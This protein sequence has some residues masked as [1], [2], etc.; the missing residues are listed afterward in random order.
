MHRDTAYENFPPRL[1][2]TKP[3]ESRSV[4]QKSRKLCVTIFHPSD[5]LSDVHCLKATYVENHGRM[6]S[7]RFLPTFCKEVPTHVVFGTIADVKC[8]F[9]NL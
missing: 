2:P 3:K 9:V 4:V 8:V 6:K 7:Q 1:T 5:V